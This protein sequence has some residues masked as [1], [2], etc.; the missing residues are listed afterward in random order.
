M[1][2]RYGFEPL[3]EIIE[4]YRRACRKRE[5]KEMVE[6]K[7]ERELRG[8]SVRSSSLFV[9]TS[10]LLLIFITGVIVAHYDLMQG[11]V[12]IAVSVLG[13]IGLGL[14]IDFYTGKPTRTRVRRRR[15]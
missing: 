4:N 1:S 11:L 14:N 10:W 5:M 8:Q 2:C 12:Y 7:T 9:V 3:E 13:F 6:N 15:R